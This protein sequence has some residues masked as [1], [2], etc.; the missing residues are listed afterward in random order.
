MITEN[1]LKHI[2]REEITKQEVTSLVLSKLNDKLDSKD[3]EQ[4]IRKIAADVVSNIFKI[5][6]QR[7]ST[8]K[9]AAAR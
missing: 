1:R 9:T 8:W 5:L 7:D 4:K 6:W 3:M 2:I